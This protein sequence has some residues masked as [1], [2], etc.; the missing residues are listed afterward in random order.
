[1][2][3]TRLRN[4]IVAAGATLALSAAAL[5]AAQPAIAEPAVT[6]G[7]TTAGMIYYRA[8]F[9]LSGSG[10]TNGWSPGTIYIHG[11]L[12]QPSG[13]LDRQYDNQCNNSTYCE[14]PTWS[15]CPAIPGVWRWSVRGSGPGGSASDSAVATVL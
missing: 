8:T 1:M 2:T 11:Y 9:T 3:P 6:P 4:K 7:S 12:Y 15:F 5:V 14:L 10:V 13:A